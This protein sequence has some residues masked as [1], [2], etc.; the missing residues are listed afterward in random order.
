M[1][2]ATL[3]M[4]L[5]LQRPRRPTPQERVAE[6]NLENDHQAAS[7]ATDPC[8]GLLCRRRWKRVTKRHDSIRD[9][10]ATALGRVSGTSATVE[11]RVL[12]PQDGADQRRG[13]IKVSK[14]GNTWILDVGVV[15]PGTQTKVVPR[16]DW[17]RRPTPVKAAKHADQDNFIPFILET[18]G[19][20]NKAARLARRSDGSR[21]GRASAQPGRPPVE[22]CRLRGLKMYSSPTPGLDG[23]PYVVGFLWRTGC[24][25]DAVQSHRHG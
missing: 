3:P 7:F 18:G 9:R 11:P 25:V 5:Q 16:R 8:H 10:L 15:C 2:D 23:R 17:R 12:Q 14:H 24:V 22:R 21:A 1:R 13:D 4:A 20:V 19:R 6:A